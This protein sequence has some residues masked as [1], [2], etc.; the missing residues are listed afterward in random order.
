MLLAAAA[1]PRS[2]AR[3]A[4]AAHAAEQE[5]ADR[6]ANEDTDELALL[7]REP[8]AVHHLVGRRLHRRA[9]VRRNGRAA[10]RGETH[11][12]TH[13]YARRGGDALQ[14]IGIGVGGGGGA[15]RAAGCRCAGARELDRGHPKQNQGRL[16]WWWRRRQRRWRQRRRGPWAAVPNDRWLRRRRRRQRQRRRQGRVQ[17][18]RPAVCAVG[19]VCARG[20]FGLVPSILAD[21]VLD[22]GALVA[23]NGGRRRRKGRQRRRWRR[24]RWRWRWRWVRRHRWWRRVR[25]R[26]GQLAAYAAVVLRGAK[27]RA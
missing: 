15:G 11:A 12:R 25:R 6:R 8:R 24:R 19:A 21:A 27:L 20:A 18:S 3:G 13:K 14:L 7:G 1:S 16:G 17:V 9:G 4:P 22:K 26:P 23:A 10:L 2:L 5:D